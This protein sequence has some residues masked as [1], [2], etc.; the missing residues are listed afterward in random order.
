MAE[1]QGTSVVCSASEVRGEA[2]AE[3]LLTETLKAREHRISGR[4]KAR[5]ETRGG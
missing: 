4:G 5:R 3:V 2:Y 1:R